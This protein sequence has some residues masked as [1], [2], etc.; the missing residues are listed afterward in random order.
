M[1]PL[2]SSDWR[3]FSQDWFCGCCEGHKITPPTAQP[4]DEASANACSSPR[5]EA[6]EC[7]QKDAVEGL[8]EKMPAACQN[9]ETEELSGQGPILKN[10]FDLTKC[11][12]HKIEVKF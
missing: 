4:S 11:L 6:V 1:L 10:N 5:F 2:P 7:S 9:L 3:D 8:V 12:L